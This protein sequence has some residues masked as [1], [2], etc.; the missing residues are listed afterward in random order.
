MGTKLALKLKRGKETLEL[1]AETQ[2]LESSLGEEKEF[3]TWGFS[4][5]DVTRRFA[6]D[7]QLDDDKG[8]WITSLSPGYPAAKAEIN[9]GDVIR[10]INGKPVTDLDEFAKLYDESIKRKDPKVYIE[11]KRDRGHK[12][13]LLEVNY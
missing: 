13:A 3:K 11:F 4:V 2:K 9:R 12:S 7:K 5:R 6:N 10:S 1:T 8:V